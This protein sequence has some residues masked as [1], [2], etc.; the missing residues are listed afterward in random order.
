MATMELE[1]LSPEGVEYNKDVDMIVVRTIDGDRGI[2]PN[3][4]PFVTGVDIGQVTIKRDDEETF[5]AASHGYMEVNPEKVTLLLQTAEFASEIDV[6]R[7][8]EAK[9]EAEKELKR[10]SEEHRSEQEAEIALQK[11]LNRLQVAK[12]SHGDIEIEEYE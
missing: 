6:Q 2:L 5:L 8:L 12:H 9:K 7:A 10:R 11:A 4:E 1:I 3:H